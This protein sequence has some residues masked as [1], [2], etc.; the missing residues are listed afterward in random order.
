MM[1]FAVGFALICGVAA[2][3]EPGPKAPEGGPL[4]GEL[5]DVDGK[6]AP[7]WVTAPA[8]FRRTDDG[9]KVICEDGSASGV[10]DLD[11]A[12]EMSRTDALGKLAQTFKASVKK[13]VQSSLAASATKDGGGASA[14]TSKQI[15]ASTDVISDVSLKGAELEATWISRA[16]TLHSL[17][18]ITLETMTDNVKKLDEKALEPKIREAVVAHAEIAWGELQIGGAPAPAH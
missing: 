16:S 8:T 13:M 11:S 6:A 9:R 18:C 2:C 14:F 1:R 12:K 5:V 4:A 3:T 15:D 17:V 7:K 10:N